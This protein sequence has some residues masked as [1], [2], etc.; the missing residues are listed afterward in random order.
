MAAQ[1]SGGGAVAHAGGK[2][3]ADHGAVQDQEREEKAER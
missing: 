3:L 1:L 2:G